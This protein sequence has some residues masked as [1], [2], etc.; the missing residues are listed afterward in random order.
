MIQILIKNSMKKWK[1]LQETPNS[2]T[3][4]PLMIVLWVKMEYFT[5]KSIF[6]QVISSI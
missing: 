4:S 6:K 5:M 2:F 3:L 1:M